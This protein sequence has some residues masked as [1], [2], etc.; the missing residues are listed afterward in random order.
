MGGWHGWLALV[1]GIIA[2]AGQWVTTAWLPVIGGAL[3][4]IAGIGSMMK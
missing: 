4:V 3:A 2:I 1:G